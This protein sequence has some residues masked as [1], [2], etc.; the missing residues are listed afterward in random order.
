[1]NERQRL[2][3]S[4]FAS[5][6]PRNLWNMRQGHYI[7]YLAFEGD[8]NL[9]FGRGRDLLKVGEV[10]GL[11]YESKALRMSVTIVNTY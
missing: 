6:S 8:I 2:E 9:R 4:Q 3:M 10:R 11:E 5:K 7:S 1:M